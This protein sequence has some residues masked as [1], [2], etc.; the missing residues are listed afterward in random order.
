MARDEWDAR[1]APYKKSQ[2]GERR[3]QGFFLILLAVGIPLI[4]FFFQDKG[5]L[6][7]YGAHKV[8]ERNISP[9]EREAI[10]KAIE[11]YK[12]GLDKIQRVVENV[13]E[14]YRAELGESYFSERW[15]VHQYEGLTLPFKYFLGIGAIFLL[16][17]VGKLIT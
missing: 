8:F 16:L 11:E 6:R 15:T 2:R 5:E 13:K 9:P 4:V 17:G 10:G 1:K 12:A 3:N 14:H 7:I